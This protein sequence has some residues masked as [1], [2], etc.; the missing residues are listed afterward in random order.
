MKQEWLEYLKEHKPELF[1]E[2]E[3]FINTQSVILAK[4]K[5]ELQESQLTV[6]RYRNLVSSN[7]LFDAK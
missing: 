2:A 6:D 4:I 7:Y 5:T 3:S 1:L